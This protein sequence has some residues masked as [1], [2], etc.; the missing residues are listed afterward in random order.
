MNE[1]EK[2]KESWRERK[3]KIRY[4]WA[5]PFI[6]IEWKCEQLSELLERWALIDILVQIG[7]LGILVSIVA[8]AYVYVTEADERLMQVENQRK[9]NQY[10]AWQVI[11]AA[12]GKP[13]NL[14][15]TFALQDLCREG[16]SLGG[17]DISK[18]YLPGLDL[19]EADLCDANFAEATL[20][21]ANLSRATLIG[22]DFYKANLSRVAFI[23]A[24]L[25]NARLNRTILIGAN[26]CD[27]NLSGA[28]LFDADLSEAKAYNA[29]FAG[30]LLQNANFAG[31]HL[32]GA[33]LRGAHLTNIK[34]WRQIKSIKYAYILSV[35]NPPDGFTE[36]AIEHGAF[37]IEDEKEWEKLKL[38]RMEE[39]KKQEAINSSEDQKKVR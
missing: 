28:E 30:A 2:I 7:R 37:S 31:A 39:K 38:K 15:R 6:F 18:A 25:R 4:K 11:N 36:W 1:V 10:Q 17:I 24:N 8:G 12:Q 32:R 3:T 26:L 27:A 13:G 22:A 19:S 9:A 34:Q 16:I 5:V 23:D 21:D 29:N 33:N 35:K 14:G 20:S